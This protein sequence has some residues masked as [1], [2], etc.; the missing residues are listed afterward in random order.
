MVARKG[1]LNMNISKQ[2]LFIWLAARV[3]DHIGGCQ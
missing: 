2:R 3:T 1:W